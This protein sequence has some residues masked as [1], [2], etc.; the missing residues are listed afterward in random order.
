[1]PVPLERSVFANAS[2][3]KRGIA[4]KMPGFPA[5]SVL[6]PAPFAPAMTV[7]VGRLTDPK[8]TLRRHRA[9]QPFVPAALQAGGDL[10]PLSLSLL[11]LAAAPFPA[12]RRAWR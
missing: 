8:R 6:F 2:G 4:A 7:R 11:Q 5:V 10:Q 12:N 1:M 3:S 9:R